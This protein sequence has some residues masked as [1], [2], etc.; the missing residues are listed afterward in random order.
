M[1]NK[2]IIFI[3]VIFSFSVYGQNILVLN[4]HLKSIYESDQIIKGIISNKNL[5]QN[6][7]IEYLDFDFNSTKEYKKNIH[8]FLLLKYKDIKFD[9]IINVNPF[10]TYDFEKVFKKSK[11]ITITSRSSIQ[12]FVN[13]TENNVEYF[14]ENILRIQPYLKKL[15][16]QEISF[17]D[18]I[19]LKKKYPHVEFEMI[20]LEDKIGLALLDLLSSKDGLLL[21]KEIK[22]EAIMNKI[23]S[24]NNPVY[25]FNLP[26]RDEYSVVFREDFF[27]KGQQ[28]INIL[29]NNI[30]NIKDN[31]VRLFSSFYSFNDE[32]LNRYN[33]FYR[34]LSERVDFFNQSDFFIL[35]NRNNLIKFSFFVLII[36]LFL[37]IF[38]LIKWKSLIKKLK[39]LKTEAEKSNEIKGKF[40]A[41]MSHEIRTPLN[42]IIGMTDI[43]KVDLLQ[44]TNNTKIKLNIIENSAKHL[45]HIVNEILDFSKIEAKK[46][47]LLEI[48]F[49]IIQLLKEISELFSNSIQEKNVQ[50]YFYFDKNIPNQVRG[51]YQKIKQILINLIN[52]AIKFTP[53]G[54][55]IVKVKMLKNLSEEGC[56]VIF[57][58]IDTGIGISQEKK[59][60][61]FESFT[62]LD[63]S[64]SRKY[65]GTGLG[66]S[67]SK[68]FLLSMKSDIYFKSRLGKG[69]IFYFKL[70]LKVSDNKNY[71]FNTKNFYIIVDSDKAIVKHVNKMLTGY[72][73]S[74]INFSD[75]S[76]FKEFFEDIVI[77]KNIKFIV[78][79]MIFMTHKNYFLKS[80]SQND[81]KKIKIL[82]KSYKN[83]DFF[84]SL[85]INY[86]FKTPLFQNDLL[87]FEQVKV[88]NYKKNQIN[89]NKKVL[90]VEDNLINAKVLIH[91]L[92]ELGVSADHAKNGYESLEKL[93]N[94]QNY[95]LI[96]MDI[97]LPEINGF[98]LTSIIRKKKIDIPII[99]VTANVYSGYKEKCLSNGMD[100]YISKPI[101]FEDLKTLVLKYLSNDL[102]DIKFLETLYGKDTFFVLVTTYLD[103]YK[104]V[105]KDLETA[106]NDRDIDQIKKLSH[107]ICGILGDLRTEKIVKIFREISSKNL[108]IEIIES[109]YSEGIKLIKII[110]FQLREVK[111]NEYFSCRR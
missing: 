16:I 73:I 85:K 95:N 54:E 58:V 49:N 105:L 47:I 13:V 53:N 24:L 20:Y 57:S 92:K 109:L 35:V 78:S 26:L 107:K 74:Y 8:E 70:K 56:R 61:L 94:K 67:I 33:I 21:V 97:Q 106:I 40:L 82:T 31:D 48:D 108:S 37:S 11:Y 51:D 81:Y 23:A 59:I 43:V 15:Y 71:N 87:K 60:K 34:N 5:K 66:L 75:F 28:I 65:G 62:Q 101:I 22:D 84:E 72:N 91:Y 69:S 10:G 98:E 4:Y 63:D 52:N 7:Y 12:S 38:I 96:F 19:K 104:K 6:V 3:F 93:K 90:I 76:E 18:L 44:E 17:Y 89:L 14:I 88:K 42:E 29:N 2:M 111:N 110:N 50:L 9:Y 100:D 99:A 39:D 86:S 103:S 68:K 27:M 1:K 77:D 79:E 30:F 64:Y 41:N 36:F 45:L 80:I 46:T 32:H 25:A 55:I 102:I 83:L